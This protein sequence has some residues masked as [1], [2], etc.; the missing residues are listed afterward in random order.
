[1]K[2]NNKLK[3]IFKVTFLFILLLSSSI[4]NAQLEEENFSVSLSHKVAIN[5]T[6]MMRSDLT[7]IEVEYMVSDNVGLN[8]SMYAGDGV[9]HMP[10][11]PVVGLVVLC[12]V[13]SASGDIDPEVL[14][15]IF[16]IPEGVTF[17]IN[18]AP[19]TYVS[20]YINPLGLEY[21]EYPEQQSRFF[22]MG[23]TGV[24]MKM[25]MPFGDNVHVVFSGFAETQLE[26]KEAQKLGLRAGISMGVVF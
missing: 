10:A 15:Y 8:Y 3:N 23:S 19:N 6:R 18:V 13:A 1:M 12:A 22:L 2:T 4:T 7:G 9:F 26:Y 14:P 21:H 17:N 5:N 24:K 25:F 20:P 16:A 11:G